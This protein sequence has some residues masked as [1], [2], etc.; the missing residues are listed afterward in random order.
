[1]PGWG[2]RI[3]RGRGRRRSQSAP[4]PVTGLAGAGR[5]GAGRTGTRRGGGKGKGR[6]RGHDDD[7]DDDGG[8]GARFSLNTP[9]RP[10]RPGRPRIGR[11]VGQFDWL[12]SASSRVQT[13]R[14]W[15]GGAPRP[16]PLLLEREQR[17][18]REA[19]GRCVVPPRGDRAGEELGGGRVRVP[20]VRIRISG[21]SAARKGE[22]DHARGWDWT[23]CRL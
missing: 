8:G 1:M 7:V 6:N 10:G 17:E 5:G 9:A 21:D 13:A 20:L 22:V 18:Q 12:R 2:R 23:S 19:E 11:D 4:R 14:H 3:R 16:L 15:R